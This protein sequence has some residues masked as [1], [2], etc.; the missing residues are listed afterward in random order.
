MTDPHEL[1]ESAERLMARFQEVV[2]KWQTALAL[3]ISSAPS[4]SNPNSRATLE[5]ARAD[6][7]RL[8]EQ[9]E[10]ELALLARERDGIQESARQKQAQCRAYEAAVEGAVRAG[11]EWEAK[12]QFATYERVLERAQV[13]EADRGVLTELIAAYGAELMR[14]R[15][16][17]AGAS[18]G[19]PSDT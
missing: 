15:A 8:S 11:N 13:L 18:G 19:P 2:A 5:S 10:R 12:R 14:V 7:D 3:S 17:C 9:L 16:L 1:H 6:F 4:T